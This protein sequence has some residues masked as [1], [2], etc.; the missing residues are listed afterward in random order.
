HLIAE[1]SR[2]SVVNAGDGM[3]EHP[4]QALLDAFTMRQHFGPDL[5]GKVV[6]ICGDIQHSR[7]A[8]SNALLLK[9]LGA[10]VRFAGPE[11]MLPP[12]AAELG[13]TVFNR[14]EPALEGADVVMMLRIQRERLGAMLFPSLREY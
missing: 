13:W 7:V 1:R 5:S 11:T 2:A 8:R 3:H 14:L 12:R 9:L 6:A 4:T 10:E